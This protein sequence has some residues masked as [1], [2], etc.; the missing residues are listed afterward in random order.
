MAL[1][2]PHPSLGGSP[3]PWILTVWTGPSVT[4]CW[5]PHPVLASGEGPKQPNTRYSIELQTGAAPGFPQSRELKTLVC[6][7]EGQEAI[8]FFMQLHLLYDNNIL[9][10]R[11]L[12]WGLGA[13]ELFACSLPKSPRGRSSLTTVS[14]CWNSAYLL[15]MACVQ[16]TV[17]GKSG[18]AG[19]EEA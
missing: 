2:C 4:E 16:Y 12:P 1:A 6:L 3:V 10:I 15:E 13:L 7:K 11:A 5:P 8:R 14:F 18:V 9:L 19:Q 17:K